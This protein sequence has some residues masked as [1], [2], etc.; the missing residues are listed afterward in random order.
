[1]SIYIFAC[2]ACMSLLAGLKGTAGGCQR[3]IKNPDDYQTCPD[4][5]IVRHINVISLYHTT[6]TS[7]I[8]YTDGTVI[9]KYPPQKNKQTKNTS[10]NSSSLIG[11]QS[12]VPGAPSS[13]STH[14]V[15]Q[16]SQGMARISAQESRPG[17]GQVAGGLRW[18]SAGQINIKT[19][20][21][22]TPGWWSSCDLMLR[23]CWAQ[24]YSLNPCC[25]PAKQML[26]NPHVQMRKSRP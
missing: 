1:M 26:L 21:G 15:S 24:Y 20:W 6:E 22:W 19:T 17:R 2:V 25:D 23:G 12:Q 9:D 8:L 18:Q 16:S 10:R 4:D 13:T 5:H 14:V 3:E 11:T 7:I